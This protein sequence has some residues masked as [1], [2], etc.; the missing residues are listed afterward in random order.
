MKVYELEAGVLG[1]GWW[2]TV[3]TSSTGPLQSCVPPS[4]RDRWGVNAVS[5]FLLTLLP[6]H[7]PEH[8]DGAEV[9][10]LPTLRPRGWVSLLPRHW[11]CPPALHPS[12]QV[13]SSLQS[14]WTR[15]PPREQAGPSLELLGE[16]MAPA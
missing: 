6:L 5:S 8:P 10:L 1:A 9:H 4:R 12:E 11:R 16:S 15:D 13:C 2:E 7:H 14:L 3:N